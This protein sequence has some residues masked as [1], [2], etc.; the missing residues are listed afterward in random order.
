MVVPRVSYMSWRNYLPG[1]F[2]SSGVIHLPFLQLPLPNLDPLLQQFY[3]W[4]WIL[5]RLGVGRVVVVGRRWRDSFDGWRSG[6]MLVLLRQGI[7]VVVV[8]SC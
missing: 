7:L 8:T 1:I 3:G 5:V 2:H 4:E 6:I